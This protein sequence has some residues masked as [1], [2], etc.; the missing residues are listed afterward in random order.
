TGPPARSLLASRSPANVLRDPC[1]TQVNSGVKDFVYDDFGALVVAKDA[2][3]G[4]EKE[5]YLFDVTVD[6]PL[7]LRG[8][9]R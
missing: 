9:L 4:A 2:G 5:V 8:D 3:G 7:G 6:L 1:S